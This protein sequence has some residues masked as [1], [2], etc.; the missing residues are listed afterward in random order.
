MD[1]ILSDFKGMLEI[2][3]I[4]AII[5]ATVFSSTFEKS[6]PVVDK[7]RVFLS[8]VMIFEAFLSLREL[9][10]LDCKLKKRLNAIRTIKTMAITNK[11]TNM[12][13][14]TDIRIPLS[15]CKLLI[16]LLYN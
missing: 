16:D 11:A 13:S 7:S 2:W 10:K 3:L 9:K 8:G 5:I 4:E 15:T 12:L 1:F 6:V 14:Y